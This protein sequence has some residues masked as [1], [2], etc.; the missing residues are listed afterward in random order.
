[1]GGRRFVLAMLLAVVGCTTDDPSPLNVTGSAFMS[2]GVCT[3]EKSDFR[4]PIL[5]VDSCHLAEDGF[6]DEAAPFQYHFDPTPAI[7]PGQTGVVATYESRFLGPTQLGVRLVDMQFWYGGTYQSPVF[8]LGFIKELAASRFTG[9]RTACANE[10]ATSPQNCWDHPVLERH[11]EPQLC[12]D[13]P[14]NGVYGSAS[15]AC[16][17]PWDDVASYNVNRLPTA[18]LSYSLQ[19]GCSTQ[20]FYGSNSS[21]P[22]GQALTYSWTIDGSITGTGNPFSTTLCPGSHSVRLLVQ[23]AGGGVDAT[24]ATF[25]VPSSPLSASIVGLTQ[26]A[27]NQICPWS[28][29]ATGGSPPYSYAWYRGATRPTELVG[30]GQQYLGNTGTSDFALRLT[31]TDATS[32]SASHTINVAVVSGTPQCAM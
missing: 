20:T 22:E 32:A 1:M 6:Q 21:D 30:T 23:D 26:V 16:Q 8:N 3:T 29:E 18:A 5:D 12:I 14:A 11:F 31:V 13:N 28:A 7:G 17:D 27:P 10:H 2:S 9:Y 15:A 25:T 4:Y 24:A 19:A